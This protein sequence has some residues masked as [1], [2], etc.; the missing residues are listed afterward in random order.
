MVGCRRGWRR[1]GPTT[2]PSQSCTKVSASKPLFHLTSRLICVH[3]ALPSMLTCASMATQP[4]STVQ[5]IHSA[6]LQ[7]VSS[8]SIRPSVHTSVRLSVTSH[9]VICNDA[10]SPCLSTLAQDQEK[11]VIKIFIVYHEEIY[12]INTIIFKSSDM[13][14]MWCWE[15]VQCKMIEMIQFDVKSYDIYFK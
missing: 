9:G 13:L 15:N 3:P 5:V 10:Q 7:P 11:S 2:R 14:I 1:T 4:T 6:T 12:L 8:P